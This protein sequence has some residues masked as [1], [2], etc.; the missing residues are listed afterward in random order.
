MNFDE[1]FEYVFSNDFMK[2]DV[3]FVNNNLM[4]QDIYNIILDEQEKEQEELTQKK[5]KK[6]NNHILDELEEE[7]E[8]EEKEYKEEGL[9]VEAEYKENIN[10]IFNYVEGEHIPDIMDFPNGSVG[11]EEKYNN[12]IYYDE[13]IKYMLSIN[14][15]SDYFERNTP[16]AFILCTNIYSLDLVK[17]EN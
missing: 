15:D 10:K 1:F 16:G 12:I 11:S 17:E 2:E 5:Q 6:E 13:N 3:I 9:N 8:S 7:E 4:Y 14:Q